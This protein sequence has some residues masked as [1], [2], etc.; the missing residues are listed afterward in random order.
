MGYIHDKL[1]SPDIKKRLL[2]SFLLFISLFFAVVVLSYYVLPQELLK[3]KQPLQN[4]DT[5]Q[6]TFV[7]TMQIFGFNSISAIV[8]VAANL[9]SQKNGY[10]KNYLAIGYVAFFALV[11][12]NA[13]VLGTWS[14]SV[15]SAP[16]PLWDRI[17]RTFD[18]AHHAGLWEML[19][20]LFIVSATAPIGIVITNG[21]DTTTRSIRSV[22]LS[23]S[24]LWVLIIGILSML[25]GA[26]VESI[27]INVVL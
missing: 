26:V 24:E 17:L 5:S 25:V 8:M 12:F 11:C 9:F 10:H 4:W 19:G 18:L 7:C 2:W 15:E 16:V 27:A 13:V 14:F 20:Q 1:G 6:N 22:Q 23:R 21:R 3:D